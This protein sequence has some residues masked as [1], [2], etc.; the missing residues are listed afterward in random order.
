MDKNARKF[1]C[2]FPKM[3]KFK[4]HHLYL[5]SRRCWTLL[6][7]LFLQNTVSEAVDFRTQL[8][9][10]ILLE[11]CPSFFF[12]RN[13]KVE[14]KTEHSIFPLAPSQPGC[15]SCFTVYRSLVVCVCQ[16]LLLKTKISV[17]HGPQCVLLMLQFLAFLFRWKKASSQGRASHILWRGKNL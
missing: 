8:D 12:Y 11:T 4:C 17:T 1:L 10:I 16:D 9:V 6:Y 3:P 13:I 14:L 15:T 5:A 2:C 7:S